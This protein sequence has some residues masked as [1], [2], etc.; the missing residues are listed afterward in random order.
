MRFFL[1]FILG[2]LERISCF[3][4]GFGLHFP[5]VCTCILAAG[6]FLLLTQFSLFAQSGSAVGYVFPAG[7]QRGT[8]FKILI[9]GRQLMNAEE[10]Q[11]S[12]TG[13]S[14]RILKRFPKLAMNNGS[15]SLPAR[16]LC[17][18]ED[19]ILREP[20]EKRAEMREETLRQREA[21]YQNP[22]RTEDEKAWLT[23]Q[24]L[25]ESYPYFEELVN[26]HRP[27]DVQRV[28]YEY[29]LNRPE[30]DPKET[31]NQALLVEVTLAPDA[32][33]GE[34]RLTVKFPSFQTSPVPF[35]V[36][37][38]PEILEL[39]PN[40][41]DE[42]PRRWDSKRQESNSWAF[43][44]LPPIQM[45]AVLNGQIRAGDVDRFR[46][47]AKKGQKIVLAVFGRCLTPFLADA[48]PGWFQP[49]LTVYGP[50]G[51][52][53]GNAHSWKNEPDPVL[54]FEAKQDGIHA[55][56]IQ[57]SLFRGRH[58]FVYRLAVGE[59]PWVTSLY[60][61]S[62]KAG[63][64]REIQIQGVNLPKEK[65]KLNNLFGTPNWDGVPMAAIRELNGQPLLRPISL[66][67][68]KEEPREAGPEQEVS[69][70]AVFY[71]RLAHR[72][73]TANFH[74]TG[75]KGERICIDLTA[76]ALDS[77]LDA[78]MELFAPNGTLTAA[79]DDR[80]SSDG[81]NIGTRTHHAD[82]FL[83]VTLPED[84][85]YTLRLSNTLYEEN[86]ENI[87]RIRFAHT[88]PDF[89]VFAETNTLKFPAA[90]QCLELQIIR[91][92][93]FDGPLE[94]VSEDPGFLIHNSRIPAG[95]ST[96]VCTV[97][98]T[99]ERWPQDLAK[100]NSKEI[101]MNQPLPLK[102]R[103]VLPPS[104]ESL[105]SRPET[106]TKPEPET[107]PETASS[108]PASGFVERQIYASEKREQAFI[109]FH[110]LPIGPLTASLSGPP[111]HLTVSLDEEPI[112][113]KREGET[114][115][116]FAPEWLKGR[117]R[118]R[119]KWRLPNR[120]YTLHP[121]C[122]GF[123]LTYQQVHDGITTF[124]VRVTDWEKAR[125]CQ[126]LIFRQ[127][128]FRTLLPNQETTP[129]AIKA[130]NELR[131]DEPQEVIPPASLEKLPPSFA[132]PAVQIRFE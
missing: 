19:A 11:I 80:T 47:E 56:E 99:K 112:L 30:R 17:L 29:F 32:E 46:F 107:K 71:G 60:P 33:C 36:G 125:K 7:G 98:I 12:G 92:G 128:W 31:L 127:H 106:E 82:P 65:L 5:K 88:E 59:L 73:E 50:D 69:L 86:P 20:E 2:L 28:F 61:P 51:R 26:L 8:T 41:T 91:L 76:G 52:E 89:F 63:N 24:E 90:T 116:I 83:A 109:Y 57:D 130:A 79:N 123:E 49:I 126:A 97:S 72:G 34:R 129:E 62:I 117:E 37:N 27:E 105:E 93:G 121:S 124:R 74:F 94:V 45:P 102:V 64:S 77:T 53:I 115:L 48:V 23:P 25:M 22:N 14:A 81:P 84:G 39:E 78:R 18:E 119:G 38:L 35:Y 42:L 120:W 95:A 15:I 4:K 96:A 104:A 66:T 58:D 85:R 21:W 75:K 44:Q 122:E 114:E 68:E 16:R 10:V 1:S 70:P 54:I 108:V 101:R 111:R 55:V 40:E 3:R 100:E 6:L 110:H 113:I 13:A 131:F 87:Y 43:V 132:F 118:K 9:G 103:A 67:V